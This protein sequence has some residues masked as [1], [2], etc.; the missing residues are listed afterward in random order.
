MGKVFSERFQVRDYELDQYGVVNNSVY[1]N[2]LEHTRHQFLHVVGIDP[3]QV[4]RSG[5]S[6]ALSE[7]NLRYRASLR[8]RE[9]FRVEVWIAELR[10]ARVVLAQRIVREPEEV[11]VLEATATA[12]FVDGAGRPKR[13]SPAHQAAFAPYLVESESP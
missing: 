10:G 9:T 8:S 11:L 5:E 13:V 1:A 6:L 4:A 3:A 12:V 2:Y 7:L